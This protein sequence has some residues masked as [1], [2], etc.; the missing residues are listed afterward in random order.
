LQCLPDFFTYTQDWLYLATAPGQSAAKAAFIVNS[1]FRQADAR[2]F[3]ISGA[4]RINPSCREAAN[5]SHVE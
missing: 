3:D 2:H 1:E 5:T 4:I